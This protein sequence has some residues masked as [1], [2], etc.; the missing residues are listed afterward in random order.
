MTNS[1]DVFI[2]VTIY[3]AM[4]EMTDIG[5]VADKPRKEWSPTQQEVWEGEE[6]YWEF[7]AAGDVEGFMELIDDRFVGWLSTAEAPANISEPRSGVED[8]FDEV[9]SGNEYRYTL[10]P[11]AI[12]PEGDIAIT[13]YRAYEEYWDEGETESDAT[14]TT[15]T[16]W[17][18]GSEWKIQGGMGRE[19]VLED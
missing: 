12:V 4:S 16:W 1:E 9:H 14:V 13:Y 19:S 5:K 3:Y 18:T 11:F 10:E 2:V 15:H 7:V 17:N 8:W 6:A